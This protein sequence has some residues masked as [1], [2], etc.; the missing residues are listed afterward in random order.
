M[1]S[2]LCARVEEKSVSL[3]VQ[4]PPGPPGPTGPPGIKVNFLCVCVCV[5]V[6]LIMMSS[7]DL[8]QVT[9]CNLIANLV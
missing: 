5:V 2:H 3:S 1:H 7:G 9:L 4:G 8:L 6:C